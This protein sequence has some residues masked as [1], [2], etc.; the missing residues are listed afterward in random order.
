MP[1][2][3]GSLTTLPAADRPDLLAPAV[4]AGAE[5]DALLTELGVVEIDAADSETA[6]TKERYGLDERDLANCVVVAGSRAGEERI[7]A[8]VVLADSRADVN[9]AVRRLLDVRKASFLPMERAVAESGM[10]YG[11]ITPIGLPASWRLL[12]DARVLERPAVVIGSGVRRSK[13]VLPGAVLGR[14]A[15]VEVIEGLG[16]RQTA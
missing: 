4:L 8:C 6:T 16:V 12:V 9:G 3:L 2:S 10:E 1:L 15:G 13:I 14:L 7:A 11:G 5:R